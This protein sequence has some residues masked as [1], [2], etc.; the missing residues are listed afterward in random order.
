MELISATPSHNAK[1]VKYVLATPDD[2]V[3]ECV[4]IHHAQWST[5][6]VSSQAGCAMACVFCATGQAGFRRHLSSDEIVQQVRFGAEQSRTSNRLN[7]V[8]MGMGEPLANYKNTW[9]SVEA[10][11]NDNQIGARHVTIS[12]VGIVPGILRLSREAIPVRLAV[13]LH[14]ANDELRR[15]LVPIN[16][17]YPLRA[18][19]RA[20]ELY[21][22]RTNRR[23]SLEWTLIDGVNDSDKDA[24]ELASFAS[25]VWAHV[26]VIPLNVSA[27]FKGRS[28]TRGGIR[29]FCSQLRSRG[30]SCTERR[31]R[32]DDVAAAC[33]QLGAGEVR[34]SLSAAPTRISAADRERDP[35]VI[36]RP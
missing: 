15:R 4:L 34:G 8:F 19:L 20:C 36:I 3:V 35:Y 17:R 26:N 9:R 31:R 2:T 29:R 13:S 5:V 25:A 7:V 6:C 27:G 28:P 11:V 14:A 21:V 32:G 16:D 12:T 33:G 30:V 1:T 23:L 24:H 10:L 18:L 22:E